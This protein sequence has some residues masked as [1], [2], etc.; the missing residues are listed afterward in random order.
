MIKTS[1]FAQLAA[2]ISYQTVHSG[3]LLCEESF[4][5]EEEQTNFLLQISQK[6]R[7]INTHSLSLSFSLYLSLKLS[8]FSFPIEK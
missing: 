8:Q 3:L 2:F 6:E 1:N 7:D 4:T 5:W